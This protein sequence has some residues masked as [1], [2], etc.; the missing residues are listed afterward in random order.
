[1]PPPRLAWFGFMPLMNPILEWAIVTSAAAPSTFSLSIAPPRPVEAVLPVMVR[2]VATTPAVPPLSASLTMPPPPSKEGSE[3]SVRLKLMVELLIVSV[4][5]WG[6]ES[7]K[8]P[9]ATQH[10]LVL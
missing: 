9:P 4:A 10:K 6:K 7:L 1:M 8:M 2:P 5:S 3:E